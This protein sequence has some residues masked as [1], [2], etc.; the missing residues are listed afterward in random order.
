MLGQRLA[1]PHILAVVGADEQYEVVS[2]SIVGVEEIRYYAQ[3]A[4]AARKEDELILLAQFVEDVL[5]KLL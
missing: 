2:G 4:E 1:N 5:L 3:E